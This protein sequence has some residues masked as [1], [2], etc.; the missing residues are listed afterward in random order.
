MNLEVLLEVEVG[1]LGLVVHAE[2]LGERGVG[3][4]AALEG[5]VKAVVGL[6]VLGHV[7]GDLGLGALGTRG[8][9]HER[10]E[11]RGERALNEEGIVGATGLPG[12]ALLG[13]HVGRVDLALLLG[14]A[15]LLLGNL[16][17]LLGRLHR[18]ANLGGEL[19]GERLELLGEGSKER[20]RGLGGGSNGDGGSNGGDDDL[21]L[22]GSL[23]LSLGGSSGGLLGGGGRGSSGRGR[24]GGSRLG[25]GLLV[26]GHRV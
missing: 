19:G 16:G 18:L 20:L 8:D 23:L 25:G 26:G 7:L 12:S 9:A 13:G 2:E 5:R 14:I 6:D 3:D 1:D 22:G 11:L 24:R 10:A 4:D 15:L 17:R 21:R